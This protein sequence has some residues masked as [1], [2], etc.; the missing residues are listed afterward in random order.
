MTLNISAHRSSDTDAGSVGVEWIM[1]T[2]NCNVSVFF[3]L[4]DD[5]TS[6]HLGHLPAASLVCEQIIISDTLRTSGMNVGICV[7]YPN[8]ISCL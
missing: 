2:A 4:H 5:F 8:L 7:A 3:C 1:A 6:F